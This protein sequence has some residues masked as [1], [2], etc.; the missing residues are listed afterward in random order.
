MRLES[1]PP[2]P[3]H[4]AWSATGAGT[5]LVFI[6]GVGMSRAVWAPQLAEFARDHRVI[7]YDMLGHGDSPLPPEQ[8]ALADYARQLRDLLDELG[9]PAAHVVG[10]SMGAL[11]AL[12][13]A[14]GWPARCL[15]VTALNAVFHRT[16]QQR[17]AV[18]AR[19]ESLDD[20][21]SPASV[22]GTLAR[23]F[24]APVPAPLQATAALAGALL[25]G[26]NRDGYARTYR[27]FASADAAHADRLPGLRPPALFMTGELDPNSSPAMSQAMAALVPGARA[28]VLPGERHMMSMASPGPVNAELRAFL[29][30]LASTDRA[31]P[32]EAE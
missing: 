26:V 21:G 32:A 23:W 14:L 3:G 30:S 22:D 6:H 10:H 13:F 17:A 8:P 24:G 15:S 11:V 1:H 12:E 16:P 9:L 20:I 29:Q 4:T 5:P 18:L 19:A 27:L 28:V 2:A 7:V 25:R 31:Q